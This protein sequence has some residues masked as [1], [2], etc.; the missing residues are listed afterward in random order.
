VDHAHAAQALLVGFADEPS[1]GFAGF[2]GAQAV[3]IDLA[4][5]STAFAQLAHHVRPDAG[6]A[7]AQPRRCVAGV[8]MSKSS[9]SASHS[10]SF[11]ELALN[12]GG[13]TGTGR[14]SCGQ[15]PMG[16]ASGPHRQRK[17]QALAFRRQLGHRRAASRCRGTSSCFLYALGH[18]AVGDFEG[19]ASVLTFRRSVTETPCALP[20]TPDPAVS[21]QT[22]F[23]HGR[24][25]V[26]RDDEVVQHLP[27]HQGQ[28]RLEIGGGCFVGARRQRA[29]PLEVVVRETHHGGGGDARRAA[30]PLPLPGHY[31]WFASGAAE[32]TLS[33]NRF[34]SR[35]IVNLVLTAAE[36]QLRY[37]RTTACG[38]S[39]SVFL[40]A[41]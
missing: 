31:R 32:R 41:G 24:N 11:V 9:L 1:Q 25:V 28:G 26:A 27:V 10:Q 22:H 12:G 38:F 40:G 18:H 7:V 6:A 36:L 19:S 2:V 34:W 3:Q 30:P 13:S 5:C 20:K 15:E 21:D 39:I 33:T 17:Q 35:N 23:G 14:G 8:S 29:V 4:L 16:C 37:S